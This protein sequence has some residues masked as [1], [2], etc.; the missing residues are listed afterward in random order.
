MTLTVRGWLYSIVAVA[1][2]FIALGMGDPSPVLVGVPAAILLTYG[3]VAAPGATPVVHAMLEFRRTQE[4]VPVVLRLGVRGSGL[5]AAVML[6]L[7]RNLEV[8]GVEGARRVGE[9]GLVLSLPDGRGEALV[10]VT[11]R[12]W[13]TYRLGGGTV[14]V[15]GPMG[16]LSARTVFSSGEELVVLPDTE[17][18]RRLVEPHA[19]N[20]HAG[21]VASRVRGPGSELAELR[22]WVAGDSPRSIN[23]R[24]SVRSDQTWV[25]ERQAERNGDLILVMDSVVVPGT[26]MDEAIARV[27]RI[28]A[29]LVKSYGGRR[30]RLGLVSLTGFVRWFGLD[31]GSV[32]QHRLL[33]AVM[34]TQAVTDPV[35]TA[36]DRVLGRVARPPSMV[37]FV[38]PLLDDEFVG[39]MRSLARAGMDVLTLSVDVSAWMPAPRDRIQVV[40]RRLWA[41][42][43][44][45]VLDRLGAAG[46]AV[47]EWRVGRSLEEVLEE[48]EEWRRRARRVRL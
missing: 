5:T 22:V 14:T 46:V 20:L 41:M 13:G 9:A 37:V 6:D 2:P 43:R 15:P 4:G 30:H 26:G 21:D 11:A 27:V 29:S 25:T 24:A 3:L 7:E 45:S 10:R 28:V 12:R 19:T 1:A 38:S 23:W 39:R 8:V 40:A 17:T 48:V 34:A 36:V 31:S 44:Q 35:W 33:A 32:H 18:V 47:G 42:E 16:I